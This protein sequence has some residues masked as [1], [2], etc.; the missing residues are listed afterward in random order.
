ML[1]NQNKFVVILGGCLI[2]AKN[3]LYSLTELHFQYSLVDSYN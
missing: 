3:I 1:I 2:N